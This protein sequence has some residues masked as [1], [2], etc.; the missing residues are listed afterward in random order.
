MKNN[1]LLGLFFVLA[2]WS[3]EFLALIFVSGS[4]LSLV[5]VAVVVTVVAVVTGERPGSPPLP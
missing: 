4:L 2:P 1:Y 5:V 3:S